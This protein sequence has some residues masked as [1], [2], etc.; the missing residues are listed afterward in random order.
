MRLV[1]RKFLFSFLFGFLP[2]LFGIKREFFVDDRRNF[3]LEVFEF[4]DVRRL[5]RRQGY[6]LS[7]LF[8]NRVHDRFIIEFFIAVEKTFH[9]F[10]DLFDPFIG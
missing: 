9:H 7:D 6:K 4:S 2:D 1:H 5:F 3:F 8:I 10:V